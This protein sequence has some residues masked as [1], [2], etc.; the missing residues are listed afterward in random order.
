MI[1][2]AALG[3]PWL[4]GQI[5]RGLSGAEPREPSADEK[6]DAAREHLDWLLTSMGRSSG[7][8]HARKHLSAYAEH[9]GAEEALRLRLV[10]TDDPAQAQAL[11]ARA[12]NEQAEAVAA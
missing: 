6:R 12:F 4:V 7:L 5:A 3:R 11:L 2:R 1:G 9:A 10:T 8:R